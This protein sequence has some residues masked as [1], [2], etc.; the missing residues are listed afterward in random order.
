METSSL[1]LLVATTERFV[2]EYVG[3]AAALMADSAAESWSA[4][5]P[6]VASACARYTSMQKALDGHY[7]WP[8][9]K[10]M[11]SDI[12]VVKAALACVGS[13]LASMDAFAE[14][15]AGNVGQLPG[16]ALNSFI[17]LDAF[18][19]AKPFINKQETLGQQ[20]VVDNYT[21]MREFYAAMQ[22]R[23]V[24][25]LDSHSAGPIE[26]LKQAWGEAL[27]AFRVV[28]RS[29]VDSDN[30]PSSE[31]L[32]AGLKKLT[33]ICVKEHLDALQS[34]SV[35]QVQTQRAQVLTRVFGAANIV[36]VQWSRFLSTAAGRMSTKEDCLVELDQFEKLTQA[37]VAGNKESF[38]SISAQWFASADE[39]ERVAAVLADLV[40]LGKDCSQVLSTDP[41]PLRG[42]RPWGSEV[43]VSDLMCL[44][45]V[46]LYR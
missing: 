26:Q 11:A 24:G 32:E 15:V 20:T 29:L 35:S 5:C 39:V 2:V 19:Q 30:K 6:A 3:T 16:A 4:N 27:A 12:A 22:P 34:L 1:K 28:E 31:E 13:A 9:H 8:D 23:V 33:D 46:R 21:K 40:K 14:I 42:L 36:G 7:A 18:S 25:A 45:L 44:E 38:A 41:T 10:D 43:G 17:A 37:W